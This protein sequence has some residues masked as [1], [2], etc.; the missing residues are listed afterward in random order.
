[1]AMSADPLPAPPARELRDRVLAALLADPS[2]V[3]VRSDAEL[4][5]AIVD[6]DHVVLLAHDPAPP[7]PLAD[8]LRALVE[9]T[10]LGRLFVVLVGAPADAE[11]VLKKAAPFWQ[12]RAQFGFYRVDAAGAPHAVKGQKSRTVARALASAASAAP[13][14]DEALAARLAEG[15]RV[16]EHDLN[17]T[18]AMRRGVPTGTIAMAAACL[19]LFGLNAYWGD[20]ADPVAT[21]RMGANRGAEVADGEVWRLLASAFLHGNFPHFA[22]NMLALVSFGTWLERVLGT[23]RWLV[24]YALSALGGSAASALADRPVMSVG[25]SGAIWG[26]MLAGVAMAWRPRGLLPP[27]AVANARRAAVVPLAINLLYSFRPGIDLLAHL[28]GGAVGFALVVSGLL[29][30]GVTPVTDKKPA[31]TPLIWTAAAALLT[32]AMAASVAV[33]L[34]TGRPWE[35]DAP[36]V[37]QRVDAGLGVTLEVPRA[38]AAAPR[39]EDR[40]DVRIASFGTLPNVPILVET[41]VQKLPQTVPPEELAAAMEQA[42]SELEA[43]APPGF[44]RSGPALLTERDGRPFVLL[45][46]DLSG[47]TVK[48]WYTIAGDRAVVIRVYAVTGRPESWKGVDEHVVASLSFN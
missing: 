13:L 26:L 43:G 33:A 42:R 48:T 46:Y 38:M 16:H 9:A 15:I 28:G 14:S 3:L 10:K 41:V 27:L 34:V 4:A 12:G 5:V 30:R 29:T 39:V 25:A 24:L 17:M 47:R 8:Q 20:S 44:V 18:M 6:G 21:W 7:V 1:M 45:S 37:Y 32:V 35:I 31:P 22:V 23:P 11:P 2:T 36:V 40:G 19:V